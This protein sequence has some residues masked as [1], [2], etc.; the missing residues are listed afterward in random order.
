[1]H[2]RSSPAKTS[3]GYTRHQDTVSRLESWRHAPNNRYLFHDSNSPPHLER[4]RPAAPSRRSPGH[5]SLEGLHGLP[6]RIVIQ[7]P[8]DLDAGA[9]LFFKIRSCSHPGIPRRSGLGPLYSYQPTTM[10]LPGSNTDIATL[11]WFCCVETTTFGRVAPKRRHSFI[12]HR[13][14]IFPTY[15]VPQSQ[16]GPRSSSGITGLC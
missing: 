5:A 3:Y 12:C 2:Y 16:V 11:K 15:P 8:S 13:I 10:T 1:M 6:S 9:H 4:Q 14:V 7:E